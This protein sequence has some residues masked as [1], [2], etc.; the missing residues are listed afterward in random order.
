MAYPSV[1]SAPSAR[2]RIIFPFRSQWRLS[3][4]PQLPPRFVLGHGIAYDTRGC[5]S[6]VG[7]HDDEA[8]IEC[9]RFERDIFFRQEPL[10]EAS[11]DLTNS[12]RTQLQFSTESELWIMT[13]GLE[14]AE[15]ERLNDQYVTS[16]KPGGRQ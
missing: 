6:F 2:V 5:L 14:L 1:S 16:W 12:H 8:L 10:F 11:R 13:I 3:T 7:L 9:I 15:K 4:R